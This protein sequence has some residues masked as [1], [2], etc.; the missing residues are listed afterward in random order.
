MSYS[1]RTS[2]VRR[3]GDWFDD[4]A[5][6][7]R[8]RDQ[9]F[10]L[11]L[12]ELDLD[13]APPSYYRGYFLR[14]Q[15]QLSTGGTSEIK[16][17]QDKFQVRL[18]VGHF[19]PEDIT[20]KTVDNQVVV[21]AKHEEKVDEHGYVSREFTRRYVLPDDIE[22]DRVASTLGADG[23]LIVE[24]PRK[25]AALLAP[26]EKSV[27]I[28]VQ[29][30]PVASKHG[31]VSRK[32]AVELE[33]VASTL[34]ADGVLVVEA[35]RRPRYS[36]PTRSRSPS[37]CRRVRWLQRCRRVANAF[38]EREDK[39]L[40]NFLTSS[41]TMDLSWIIEN[42][43]SGYSPSFLTVATATLLVAVAYYIFKN[44]GLPPGPLGVPFFGFWPF[45]DQNEIHLQFEKLK[46][47]YGDV[48]S[49]SYT[50]TLYIN[51][52][53]SKAVRETILAKSDCFTKRSDGYNFMAD[54]FEGG[55]L[56]QHSEEWKTN[57]KFFL[58]SFKERV[59]M[60]VKDLLSGSLYDSV[61]STV[62][63][64]REKTGQTLNIVELLLD[65]CNANIRLTLF[66]E[67]G[68][69]EEQVREINELYV[70]IMYCF[71]SPLL[72][73]SGN[74]GK[75]I[76]FPFFTPGY[77]EAKAN[78]KKIEKILY[79]IID[80][81]KATF[82]EDHVRDIIDEYIRERTVRGRKGDP[83]AQ[84]FTDK[85]LMSS[86][87]QFLGDGVFSVA[88]LIALYIHAL[89]EHPEE[90]DNIY[91]ELMEVVGKDRQPTFE[92]K[93]R[94]S[95]TNAFIQEALRASELIGLFPGLECTQET[96]VRGYRIPK[97]SVLV[98]N[99]FNMHND[100]EVYEEPQ[101]FNPRRFVVTEGKRKPE[102]PV[103]F[104]VGKR[105]CI[106]ETFVMNQ[107]FLFLTS[108]VKTFHISTAPEVTNR[109][110]ELFTEG[111]LSIVLRPR[112]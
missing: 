89:L 91:R 8:I 52:G 29:A 11:G 111:K 57:R 16:A 3:G 5:F 84:H 106:G 49:F 103:T 99:S 40:K 58:Q 97:G 66:G 109:H 102:P 110:S 30:S 34:G 28:K 79:Q 15:R 92:D 54:I 19:A 78:S 47:K 82:D 100:P 12:S 27:P 48:F 67:S 10:G 56:M 83:T 76:I 6:P 61:N 45:I 95:Y 63:E 41:A 71:T 86:L 70:A 50:G 25:R 69:S 36:H 26:N 22:L 53:S 32:K 4:F 33:R 87:M 90:Q 7:S 38:V 105:S 73:V 112:N 85:G 60:S 72:L 46:K 20:V 93:N 31:Y 2:L 75:Y 39:Y 81:H 101:K 43:T 108:L 94:L 51:L 104:G 35:P 17:E 62:A 44:R 13:D 9:H 1:T 65:K 98:L 74:I 24:A 42:A 21:T 107:V 23:V 14:P 68:I 18:D 37:K 96:T 55:V 64:L 77:K 59:A 88:A 80:E